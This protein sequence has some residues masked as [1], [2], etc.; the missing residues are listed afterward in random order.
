MAVGIL[1]L[2]VFATG[3]WEGGGLIAVSMLQVF[4]I[5][6]LLFSGVGRTV[7]VYVAS[8]PLGVSQHAQPQSRAPEGPASRDQDRDPGSASP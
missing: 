6:F 7:P 2:P 1:C 4:S 3:N 8:P 5:S